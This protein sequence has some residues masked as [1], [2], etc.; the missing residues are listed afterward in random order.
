MILTVSALTVLL[1]CK[2]RQIRIHF[3]NAE[4]YRIEGRLDAAMDEYR[5]VLAM[6]PEAVDAR[7]NLGFLHDKV[8]RPDSALFHYRHAIVADPAFVEAHF[9]M[10][11]VF[12]RLGRVDSAETAYGRAVRLEPTHHEA[13]NNLGVVLETQG[14]VEA[15]IEQYQ[16]ATEADPSFA[17]AYHNLGRVLFLSG[18]SAESIEAYRKTIE[19]RPNLAQAHND[20]G[21]ALAQTEAVDAAISH[22]ERALAIDPD[23]ELARRN[24]EGVKEM[25]ESLNR[26]KQAGEMRA[27]HILVSNEDLALVLIGL[28]NEGADFAT[29]AKTHSKDP[30]GATGG[31]IGS[32]KPGDL[33]EDFERIVRGLG[34]GE[35]GG[36]LR[37]A[38]GWH[39]IE[40]IY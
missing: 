12:A 20:L 13:R 11:V 17:E 30:S 40:R 2:E 8:G 39:V 33:H 35:M 32:F 7:N 29:L 4:R 21:T 23:F 24:L 27:R 9:N 18:K 28:L 36:P 31:D 5:A 34:P 37:T 1:G 3:E 25:K 14:R 26:S 16:K 38:L 6:D 15:A 19:I 22:Y 10:G